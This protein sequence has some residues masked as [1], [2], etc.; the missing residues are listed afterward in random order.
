MIT[1]RLNTMKFDLNPPFQQMDVTICCIKYTNFTINRISQLA[2]QVLYMSLLTLLTV[3][4]H[5][6][7]CSFQLLEHGLI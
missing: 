3:F 4:V 7:A 1:D 6:Y 5:P 2:L